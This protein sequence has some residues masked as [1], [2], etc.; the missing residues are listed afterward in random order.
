M[1]AIDGRAHGVHL[2]DNHHLVAEAGVTDGHLK[3]IDET[4]VAKEAAA[5]AAEDF[6]PDHS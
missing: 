6:I 5:S 3:E 4:T 1:M 2:A